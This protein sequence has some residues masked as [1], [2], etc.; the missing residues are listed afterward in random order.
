MLTSGGVNA[1][2][3]WQRV[4]ELWRC[5]HVDHKHSSQEAGLEE[6]RFCLFHTPGLISAASR[7]LSS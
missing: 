4:L 6:V 3:A 7:P 5:F 1:L 2:Y